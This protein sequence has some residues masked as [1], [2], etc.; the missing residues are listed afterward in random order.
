MA[1]TGGIYFTGAFSLLT[2]GLYWKRASRVGAH[3]AI[4]SGI[5][6]AAGLKPVKLAL[7]HELSAE[8]VGLGS[9]ALSVVVFVVGS[10]LFPDQRGGDA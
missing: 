5:F 4:A 8:T 10:L 1:I 6:A 3:L 7:G 2:G 9:V